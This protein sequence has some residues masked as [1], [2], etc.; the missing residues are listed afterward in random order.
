[1]RNKK[2]LLLLACTLFAAGCAD[3]AATKDDCKADE[4]W[5]ESTQGCIPESNENCG[6]AGNVCT[7]G[8]VCIDSQ[9]MC[10]GADGKGEACSFTCCDGVCRDTNSDAVSCGTCGNKCDPGYA[11]QS[12]SCSANCIAG[13]EMCTLSDGTSKCVDLTSNPQHC[14]ECG[15]ACPGKDASLH[16]SSG[17]CNAGACAIVCEKGYVDSDDDLSNGCETEVSFECG[18]GIVEL[19]EMCDGTRLNDQTCATV[20]GEGSRGTLHCNATCLGFD[21]SDCSAPTT[22]GNGSIESQY[23]KCDGLNV[24]GLTCADVVGEGSVGKLLCSANCSDFDT[25][26]CTASTTCGNNELDSTEVCDGTALNNATCESVVG[27]GSTGTVKCNDKCTGYDV[28]GC[29]AKSVCGNGILE[30]GEECDGISFSNNATCETVNGAGSKGALQCDSSCKIISTQCSAASTCGNGK[31]DGS[32]KC[33]GTLLNDQTCE[34]IVGIGSKGNVS[35]LSNCTGFDISKCTAPA[36]CGNGIIETGEVCDGVRLNDQTCETIVGHGS[37]GTLQCNSTCTGYIT[38]KCSSSTTCGNGIIET[39]EV[40]DGVKLQSATCN[41]LVGSGSVGTVTCGDDCTYYNLSGCSARTTCGN[42]KID[43]SEV[44]E[45]GDV[46]GETCES[47]V[48]HGSTGTLKCSSTCYTFDTSGCSAAV[49]CGNGS[50]DAG[51]VCDGTNVAGLTCA[52]VVGYGSKGSLKC[53]SNCMAYDTSL[54][55]A[56]VKCGN[57]KIDAGEVCDGSLLNNATCSSQVGYGSTGTLKCNSTCSGYDKS[58]CSEAVKC[59]NGVIDAGEVCDGSLLNDWTCL[60]QVGYGST[61]TP[62]C[63]STCTGY[64]NG[65][66]TAEVKCGN[67][68]LDDGEICDGTLLNGATCATALGSG[69]TGMLRCNNTCDG[70]DMT[71]CST[72]ETCGNG[73]IDAGEECDGKKFNGSYT[74]CSGYNSNLYA[75]GGSLKC[76]S[77]CTVDVS[78]CIKLCGNGSVNYSKGEE[79]DYNA[80]T[81]ET[82]FLSS[83]NTCAKVVGEGSMGT[84]ACTDECKLNVNGCTAAAYCGDGMV[85]T[86][87]EECDGTMFAKGSDCSIY[88]DSY[89]SGT[90]V[91]CLSSCKVDVSD[92]VLK[93]YCGDGSVNT[94]SEYCDGSS[95]RDNVTTCAGWQP[96]LYSSGNV[97][98]NNSDCSID[99]SECVAKPTKLCGNGVL[100]ASN[101]EFCDGTQSMFKSCAEWS[102][103]FDG[104]TLACNSDCTIDD[105]GCTQKYVAQCGNNILDPGEE[106]DGSKYAFSETKTGCNAYAPTIYQKG[107]LSCNDDCTVNTSA[108]TKFCGNGSL[109]TTYNGVTIGEV[110]DGTKFT[111]AFAS[112]AKIVGTGS[113]GTLK[114]SDD[115]KSVDSSG[116]SA[117]S[118][119]GDGV[120]DSSEQC[121]GTSFHNNQTDCSYW[122]SSYTSGKV[123][124]TDSCNVG[125]DNCVTKADPICGDGIIN[126]SSEECDGTSFSD[127]ANTCEKVGNF[128]G[129][130]LKCT[131]G[132]KLDTSSCTAKIV[133]GC[134][135]GVL[136]DDT[137]YCDGDEFYITDCSEYSPIYTSGKLACTSD[138]NFDLSNCK[139]AACGDGNLDS[140]EECDGTKFQPEWNTCAKVSSLYS[141]GTLKCTDDC[142]VD[143]SQCTKYCGNGV[144]DTNEEC[145]GTKFDPAMDECSD[146]IKDTIGTLGCTNTCEVDYSQC[147]AAP[148]AYCGDGI[149]NTASEECDGAAFLLDVVNCSDWSSVYT[150]GKLTCNSNCTVNESA[151]VKPPA[152]TCGDGT[153]DDSKEECDGSSFIY[154]IKTCSEYSSSYN[155]GFLSCNDKCE[156]DDSN[157]AYVTENLCGNGKLDDNEWCDGTLFIDNA[158][159]C[160]DWGSYASGNVVC[161][162]MCELSFDQCVSN[163]TDKCGDGKVNLDEKCDGSEFLLGMTSCSDWDS[164]YTS[165]T[166]TCNS[167][168]TVNYSACSGSTTTDTCGD[169]KLGDSE[170]CDNGQFMFGITSCAEYSPTQYA[171]GSLKC[172]SSCEIDTSDC[173]NKVPD[174]TEYDYRC[175]GSSSQACMDLNNTGDIKWWEWES[176]ASTQTC[177]TTSDASDGG[178]KNVTV[179]HDVAWCSFFWLDASTHAGYGR[180]LL[181]DG[182]TASSVIAQMRCTDDLSKPV[183]QWTEIDAVHNAGCTD[184]YANTEYM[185]GSY[186]GAA[187]KNYCT[188]VFLVGGDDE[189]IACP[190]IR[191]GA[192]TPIVIEDNTTLDESILRTFVSTVACNEGDVRCSDNVLELCDSGAWTT[193]ETCTGST[194]VCDATAEACVAGSSTSSYDVTEDMSSFTA[195][196]TYATTNTANHGTA[197]T[198][199]VKGAIYTSEHVI[200]G[201]TAIMRPSQS[202]SVQVTGLSSGLGLVS[203]KYAS[204]NA[205][206]AA[207]T[208]TISDGTTT[209]TLSVP[210]GSTSP[211]TYTHTFANP[212]ATTLT[213]STSGTSKG[214]LLIDDVRWTSAP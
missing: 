204:W 101:N 44:C 166:V 142:E 103:E 99:Y 193:Y 32:E 54:C 104:G 162:A 200:D 107:T 144:L 196:T 20:V 59:G 68:K 75:S 211:Q 8:N 84:L 161:T 22:C 194:P 27:M 73:V 3:K 79:C 126:A 169:G 92:C 2:E 72:P 31:I 135:D 203:F 145:D 81:E 1:M 80:D 24:N 164:H 209:D 78:E 96:T 151:C 108:C 174:C 131:T 181:P 23:E 67:G 111:S 42:G 171:S 102:D 130:T 121:D 148:T 100:D 25:S 158:T 192:S 125:Y 129:G 46:Q 28:S 127:S 214:R 41:S 5:N 149:V 47:I 172:S 29:T 198:I 139:V 74:S 176:C 165:G 134:G 98:C 4:V 206:E 199:T 36:T 137:E 6:V 157:C 180:I 17:Y 189:I 114:C 88:S 70:Y 63:N 190:N 208:M 128:S 90:N 97:K 147:H 43:A 117:A 9:C 64:T 61:G 71:N 155:A 51:E 15:T 62:A 93:P 39:G 183:S 57:G 133:S 65:T 143:D 160:S 19:G 173:V 205:T 76:S 87:S 86:S 85:N 170:Y 156:I 77:N 13:Q 123:N 106:C 38:D 91:K 178:C 55:T 122:N 201:T 10:V 146:W 184:C 186:T 49:S 53:A 191:E 60:K 175:V 150:S 213:I 132:C 45:S 7:N 18:N 26:M 82:T 109:N 37:K 33:D 48:G 14:G 152:S 188:F 95:F 35:C 89:K 34:S 58:G 12:G 141:G 168:C 110:C 177:Y 11:C 140:N 195:N 187:G 210:A 105:S 124:C 115:C 52:N 16:I 202:T 40:C 94:S 212:S 21:T 207:V 116:C 159:A 153:L 56:E 118:Y 30:I 182:V 163:Q 69:S 112:C 83:K 136:D 197:G 66:C 185:T 167:D 120:V 113:T 119:C 138:C 179:K 50:I 154:D